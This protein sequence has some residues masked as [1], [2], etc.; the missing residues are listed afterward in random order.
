M[1]K[2]YNLKALKRRPGKVRIYADAAKV[3]IHIQLDAIVVNDIKNEAERMGLPYEALI[4]SILHRFTT[5]EL[6][7]TVSSAG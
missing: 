5:G 4:N 7:D 1:K 3:S 2:E 6:V